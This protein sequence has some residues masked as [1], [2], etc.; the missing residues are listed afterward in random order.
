MKTFAHRARPVRNR[1]YECLRHIVAMNVMQRLTP[2]IRKHDF[3]AARDRRKNL[4]IKVRSRV[5]RHPSRPHKMPRMQNGDRKAILRVLSQQVFLDSRLAS[6]IIA[7]RS[8]RSVLGYRNLDPHPVHPNGA[9]MQ[10]LLHAP[11]K[12]FNQLPRAVQ[13]V[14]GEVDHHLRAQR[15]NT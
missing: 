2:K 11:A 15:A 13:G 8:A 10:K 14:T 5:E 7:D 6:S 4:R 1:L 9:A 3:L 12:R